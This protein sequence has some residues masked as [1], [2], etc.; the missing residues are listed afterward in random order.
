MLL[1]G[2]LPVGLS[3][4]VGGHAVSLEPVT[5]IMQMGYPMAALENMPTKLHYV[6]L[7]GLKLVEA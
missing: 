1:A 7:V 4:S 3:F 6:A 5:S 2:L